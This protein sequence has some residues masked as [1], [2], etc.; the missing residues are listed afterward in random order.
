LNPA[1]QST[2]GTSTEAVVA[3]RSRRHDLMSALATA[4]PTVSVT[5]PFTIHVTCSK[6]CG[7]IAPEIFRNCD[8]FRFDFRRAATSTQPEDIPAN[9]L[10]PHKALAS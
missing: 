2:A 6:S 4:V 10:M 3:D 7:Q 8:S 5:V 1:E 9:L